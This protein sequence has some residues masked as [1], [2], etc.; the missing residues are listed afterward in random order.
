[1]KK[2]YKEFQEQVLEKTLSPEDID[3]LIDKSIEGVTA[4][5]ND[6]KRNKED[7]STAKSVLKW[8]QGVRAT[9]EKEGSLHPSTV[10]SIMKTVA[11]VSSGRY[12][13]MVPGWKSSPQ[14]KVP[15]DFSNEELNEGMTSNVAKMTA[16]GLKKRS[17]SLGNQ[18]ESATDIGEKINYLSKQLNAVAGIALVAVS[19]SDEGLLS[20]GMILTSL[21]SSNEP[22]ENL[23]TLFED[24]C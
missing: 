4:I 2:T 16:I 11:G 3:D 9:F 23:D 12:G 18:V 20:K 5:K 8:L 15:K 6:K 22:D 13:Y 10:L 17:I 1:M 24:L 19:M 21:L 14:G 7:V